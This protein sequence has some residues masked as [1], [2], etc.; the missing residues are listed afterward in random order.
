M[1]VLSTLGRRL[2]GVGGP[3]AG[4]PVDGGDVPG[5]LQLARDLQR[6][7]A[8]WLRLLPCVAAAA[9]GALTHG[10]NSH[11]RKSRFGRLTW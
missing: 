6:R 11:F 2:L 8:L 10:V 5:G 3:I 7:P 1:P 4:A 9:A